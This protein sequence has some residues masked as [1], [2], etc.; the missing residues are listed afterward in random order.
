MLLGVCSIPWTHSPGPTSCRAL[1]V[2]AL[3]YS[4]SVFIFRALLHCCTASCCF[5]SSSSLKVQVL[6][7]YLCSSEQ[8]VSSYKSSFKPCQPVCN[9]SSFFFPRLFASV[10]TVFMCCSFS[11]L[12]SLAPCVTPCCLSTS[13]AHVC[14]A[15]TL[16]RA[17]VASLP[18]LCFI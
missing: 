16:L 7:C 13:P 12:N 18:S 4:C 14:I 5:P 11:R 10:G 17:L 9:L 3:L 2:G 8:T 1:P 6:V 15:V